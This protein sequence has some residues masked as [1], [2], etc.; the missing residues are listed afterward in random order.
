MSGEKR[1]CAFFFVVCNV[2]IAFSRSGFVFSAGGVRSGAKRSVRESVFHGTSRFSRGRGAG[3]LSGMALTARVLT[4]C[5]K[6]GAT[7]LL[8][9]FLDR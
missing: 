1:A 8:A 4:W 5:R 7:R 2:R 9:G 3:L 6:P